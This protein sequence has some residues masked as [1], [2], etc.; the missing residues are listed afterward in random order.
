MKAPDHPIEIE[1]ERAYELAHY[2]GATQADQ[3]RYKAATVA[4]LEARKIAKSEASSQRKSHER[5]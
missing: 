1:F 4:L 5:T 2:P 3:D